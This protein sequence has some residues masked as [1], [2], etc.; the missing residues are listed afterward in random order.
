MTQSK[1]R[2][3]ESSEEKTRHVRKMRS[4]VRMYGGKEKDCAKWGETIRS[5]RRRSVWSNEQNRT[6]LHRGRNS[7][8]FILVPTLTFYDRQ[9][10]SVVRA[11][12]KYVYRATSSIRQ[13]R[14]TNSS[15][16]L[17]TEKKENEVKRQK[18]FTRAT[19]T[20]LDDP[21][22]GLQSRLTPSRSVY[23]GLPTERDEVCLNNVFLLDGTNVE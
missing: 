21:T 8:S 15:T 6:N 7:G 3:R 16:E 5:G 11:T 13:H 18:W 19:S 4:L 9:R 14:R 2:P 20:Q 22:H 12:T 10:V 17:S 1:W 23:M